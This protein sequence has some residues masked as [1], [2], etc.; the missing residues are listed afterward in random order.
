ML[1]HD[2]HSTEISSYKA[3]EEEGVTLFGRKP[4]EVLEAFHASGLAAQGFS[5]LGRIVPQRAVLIGQEGQNTS[6]FEGEPLYAGTFIR[7]TNES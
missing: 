4:K 6:L 2:R 1:T 5:I 3:D 7:R